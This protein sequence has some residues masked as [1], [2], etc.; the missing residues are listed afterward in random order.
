M[1]K[2]L[3]LSKKHLT[4]FGTA[5]LVKLLVGLGVF[6]LTVFRAPAFAQ[7]TLDLPAIELTQMAAGLV[8]PVHITYAGDGSGRLFIVEQRG[9]IQILNG[10]LAET[11]F[12][13][14]EDRVES[15]DMGGGNEEGLLGLAFPPGYTEKGYFYVYYTMRDGDNV[16]SR[17][18]LSADPNLADPDSEE[19]ILVLPH[20]QYRN[21]NGGQIAFG[22]DGY[23]YIG[24]GDGGGGGDPL[25]NAQDP[26]SL[27]GKLLRIDVEK[28]L[29]NANFKSRQ[30]PY[31]LGYRCIVKDEAVNEGYTIPDDNPFYDDP[32]YRPEIWA[33]G[34]RNPWRFSFDR[35]S[36]DLFIA[37]VGQN[38]WEEINFQPA[39][40]PG[41]ENYGWNIMEGEECFGSGACD[42]AGL[43]LPVF[44]YP[45]FSSSDCSITGGY[46]YRGSAY[47]ALDGIYVYGDFCSGRIWGMQ[48]QE[49]STWSSGL[50]GSTNFKISSFGVDE[51]G[52]I[53]VADMSGGSI[54]QI[55]VP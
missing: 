44:V 45:I 17:F 13:N 48:Q 14:I 8:R 3:H 29:T 39:D 47:P 23:L 5:L 11:P 35:E 1:F 16:V 55:N 7:D 36:G 18:Q 9:R 46:V 50:L 43:T 26:L 40:S 2:K 51:D 54:Y 33:L 38:R 22:L 15:P 24:T 4:W 42:T 25:N 10:E 6:A 20:P 49:D 32:A 41:G 34:L 37:D 31:D 28:E 21:H 27:N 19:Q 52:E 12:L 53:Y 30:A